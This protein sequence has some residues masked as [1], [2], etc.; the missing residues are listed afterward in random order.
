MLG[1][2]KMHLESHYGIYWWE[3]EFEWSAATG[4]TLSNLTYMS[5]NE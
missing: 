2:I 4:I 3:Q 5:L 1:E